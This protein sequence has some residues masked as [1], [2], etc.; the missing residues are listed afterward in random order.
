MNLRIL[1]LL[2]AGGCAAK[3][4]RPDDA[5]A[6]VHRAEAQRE[7]SEAAAHEQKYDPHA[8][9][10]HTTRSGEADFY[11]SYN[12]TAWHREE[13]ARLTEHARAHQA[14][15]AELEKFEADECK[16]FAPAARAACAVAGPFARVEDTADGVRY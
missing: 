11:S 12:P 9:A 4:V 2:L 1:V 13:A 14:A 3:P 16:P 10:H 5:S 8:E 15:A 6:Q 7:L